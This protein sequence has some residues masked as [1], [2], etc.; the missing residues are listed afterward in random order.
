VNV[1][2]VL[3]S[4]R[5]N[6]E[7]SKRFAREKTSIGEEIQVVLLDKSDGVAQPDLTFQQ[8]AR[9]AVIKEYFFGDVRH[10][11]SP[12][13]QQV[14]FDSLVIYSW[15]DEQGLVR[16]EP[17]P[18]MSHWTLAVMYASL[19]DS[20]AVVKLANIMGFVYVADVD[21]ERRKVK[22]LAPIAGRLGDRPML[23][24]KWPEPHI[25]LLG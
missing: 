8:L 9:E 16:T 13:T 6:A 12:F 3:D 5:M 15:T 4:T 18:H 14:D 23:W 1:I 20:P 24:G 25:N 19:K 10:T 21:S 17:S 11:L 22:I 7:L 2:V